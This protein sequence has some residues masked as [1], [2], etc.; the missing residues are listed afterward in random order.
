MFGRMPGTERDPYEILG[1]SPA[2]SPDQIKRAFRRLA[3]KF[4]PDVSAKAGDDERFRAAR[5]AYE[6]LI[7]PEQRAR[8]DRRRDSGGPYRPGYTAPAAEPLRR[9]QRYDRGPLSPGEPRF[10][11][12]TTDAR[13]FEIDAVL[14]RDEARTGL[15]FPFHYHLGPKLVT[16]NITIPP[17]VK[18][19]DRFA[20]RVEVAPT[21]YLQLLVHIDVD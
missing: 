14:S 15:T 7:D 5:K 21:L 8:A 17:G 6:Q 3:R 16:E 4:H 2:A 11:G 12:R 20:Y 19:G 10:E 9:R 1:I 18:P 13:T